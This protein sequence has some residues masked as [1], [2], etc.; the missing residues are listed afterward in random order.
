MVFVLSLFFAACGGSTPEPTD[1]N[2]CGED[3]C[4]E[5]PGGSTTLCA[6][7]VTEA[8]PTGVCS[9]NR[10]GVCEWEVRECPEPQ[11]QA[12][13]GLTGAPCGEGQYCDF[14]LDAQCGAADQMGVCRARAEMCPANH[15]PVCGCDGESASCSG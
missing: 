7:G 10:D 15:D 13:G 9:R 8:G 3:A 5:N 4:G 1:P 6:D 14:A 12:C 11:E 2:A